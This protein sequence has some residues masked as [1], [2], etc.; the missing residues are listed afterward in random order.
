MIHTELKNHR[1]YA[2]NEMIDCLQHDNQ[3]IRAYWN[4]MDAL[5]KYNAQQINI[6]FK[7]KVIKTS[8]PPVVD[9]RPKPVQGHKN[10]RR[11]GS[12]G[13]KPDMS[14]TEHFKIEIEE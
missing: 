5:K 14:E 1:L 10:N 13:P 7:G 11:K 6:S 8:E 3:F 4:L 2:T 9:T 12:R